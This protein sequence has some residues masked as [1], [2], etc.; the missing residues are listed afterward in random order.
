MNGPWAATGTSSTVAIA[1]PS[2]R[3]WRGCCKCR[4]SKLFAV[5]QS[6]SD[7]GSNLKPGGWWESADFGGIVK[8][9]DGSVTEDSHYSQ[10]MDQCERAMAK[11]GMNFRVANHV[12][13]LLNKVGF[14]NVECRTIKAPIGPWA[15][16]PT[17]RLVGQYLSTS[18]SDFMTAFAAKPFR[19]LGME[20]AEIEVFIAKARKDMKD[21]KQHAYLEFKFWKGQ[22]PV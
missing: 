20:P 6:P 18:M 13:E 17:L 11:F 16:D 22:K 21:P 15:R 7:H 14:V 2:S 8:C 5:A 10:F 9:D 3:A 4:L 1:S 12:G 19:A